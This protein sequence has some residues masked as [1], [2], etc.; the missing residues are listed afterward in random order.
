M[1]AGRANARRCLKRYAPRNRIH[2]MRTNRLIAFLL[3]LLPWAAQAADTSWPP[4]PKTGFISGRAATTTDVDAGNAA[5]VARVGE[6]VIGK[7]IA[8]TIPQ[9]AYYVEGKEKPPVIV[10]QAEEAQGHK[11][12]GARYL[13]GKEAVGLISDFELLGVNPK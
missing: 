6:T 2:R 5:F 8:I 11:M 7:P 1:R 10:I 13:N 9:Y 3:G 12:I 4:L